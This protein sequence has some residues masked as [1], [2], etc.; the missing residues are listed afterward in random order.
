MMPAEAC[1]FTEQTPAGILKWEHTNMPETPIYVPEPSH[2]D[3]R[4]RI[5][6]DE[7]HLLNSES[8]EP[9]ESRRYGANEEWRVR[10]SGLFETLDDAEVAVSRLVDLGIERS[11]LS[12][13]LRDPDEA[14]GTVA[15]ST[16]AGT[17]S[18][19]AAGRGSIL[20]GT[21]GLVMGSL[22]AAAT[23]IVIPG[24]GLIAGPIAG[25]LAGAGAGGIA[26]GAVGA[27]VGAGIP[28]E[29]A[30]DYHAG[31]AAGGVVVIAEVSP[32]LEAQAR[33]ILE[34]AAF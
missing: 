9:S 11:H 6:A 13:I 4:V 23:S 32:A 28:E 8:V 19:E 17:H 29:T 34:Q 10:L 15:T 25:A 27:L 5:D 26:G 7:Q 31:I 21:I 14:E 1:P 33:T 18:G 12:L 24:I 22:I 3:M 16:V 20:G 2:G 30:H